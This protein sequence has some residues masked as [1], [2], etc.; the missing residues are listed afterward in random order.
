[1]SVIESLAYDLLGNL[2]KQNADVVIGSRVIQHL[3]NERSERR[4]EDVRARTNMSC[5]ETAQCEHLL[6]SAQLALSPNAYKE[7]ISGTEAI[8]RSPFQQLMALDTLCAMIRRSSMVG[9]IYHIFMRLRTVLEAPWIG[10]THARWFI[11]LLSSHMV[12]AYNVRRRMG[13]TASVR[14]EV[15]KSLCFFPTAR[16][17]SMYVVHTDTQATEC[18]LKISRSLD[19][20]IKMFNDVQQRAFQ[21]R[22]AITTDEGKSYDYYYMASKVGRGASK[23][24]M[25]LKNNAQE[26]GVT[27]TKVYRD[28]E[29]ERDIYK[30]LLWCQGYKSGV[31]IYF[32]S[33]IKHIIGQIMHKLLAM[34]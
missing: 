11:N 14:A 10:A 26:V 7:F 24:N 16:L 20:L 28:R 18:L 5:E 15:A 19:H 31:S 12:V 27:F 29:P 25:A 8:V 23:Q 9:H 17:H 21:R 3:L 2:S 1:M 4:G 32:I 13:K 33:L 30:N 34:Y 6:I 22:P